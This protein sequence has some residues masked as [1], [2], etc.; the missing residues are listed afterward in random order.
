[1]ERVLYG[2]MDEPEFLDDLLE[3]IF[4]WELGRMEQVLA[5]G[6]DAWVH[7]AWY[8]GCDFWTPKSF[9]RLLKPRLQKLVAKAHS[10][11]APFRYIITKGWRP[12]LNDLL[13]LG[14]DCLAGVDPVQDRLDLAEVKQAAGDR[15]CL[16]GG[17]NSGI[18]LSEW[19][20]AAI[21]RAVRQAVETLAPGGGFILYPVDAVFD[22][23]PWE[24]VQ[25]LIDEWLLCRE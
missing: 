18:M 23:Q 22:T 5:E 16:I 25:A 12:L 19:D 11:N 15:L 3:V 10:H 24:K 9:R 20:E 4:E 17:V 21:R 13:E 14:I 8:E 6:V 1:M 2:Q 7:M